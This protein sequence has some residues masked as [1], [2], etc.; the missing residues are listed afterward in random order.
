MDP[1]EAEEPLWQCWKDI[2]DY[3]CFLGKELQ[4]KAENDGRN[5]HIFGMRK[6]FWP[7]VI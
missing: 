5:F 6:S 2:F 4:L 1:E 7:I 3:Q